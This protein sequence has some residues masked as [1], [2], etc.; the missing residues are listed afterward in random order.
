M[1]HWRSPGGHKYGA[2]AITIDGIKF[3]SQKEGARYAELKLLAKAGE[4]NGLELQP[5]FDFSINGS[6]MFTYIADFAY[7]EKSGERVIE[8]CKGLKLPVYKLKKKIIEAS[9]HI[10]ITEI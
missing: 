5:S 1:T 8:D 6:K 2:K 4:I 3:Q 10:E 7:Y 9:H